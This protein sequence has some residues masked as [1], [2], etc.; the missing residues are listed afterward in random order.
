MF[1]RIFKYLYIHVISFRNFILIWEQ[2]LCRLPYYVFLVL[3]FIPRFS[4]ITALNY[5]IITESVLALSACKTWLVIIGEF[6]YLY[7]LFKWY[8]NT[9]ETS[10]DTTLHIWEYIYRWPL[11]CPRII[12]LHVSLAAGMNMKMYTIMLI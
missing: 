9:T 12:Y 7:C 11:T 4:I 1:S 6:D 10:I 3:I 8:L 2:K 5:L